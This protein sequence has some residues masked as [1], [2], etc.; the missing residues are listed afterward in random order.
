MA[1]KPFSRQAPCPGSGREVGKQ[2]RS[3]VR[4]AEC[5]ECRRPIQV[6]ADGTLY[7]HVMVYTI[8]YAD[9]PRP[10]PT[11]ASWCDECGTSDDPCRCESGT[12]VV[13]ELIDGSLLGRPS[14]PDAG[15]VDQDAGPGDRA[16]RHIDGTGCANSS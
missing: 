10:G 14:E 12:P 6:H 5:P 13:P 11:D 9:D 15:S 2:P 4:R 7:E 16:G 3:K 1:G 8:N